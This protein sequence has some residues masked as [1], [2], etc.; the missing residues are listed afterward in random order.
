MPS[1]ENEKKWKQRRHKISK[2]MV[3]R[4]RNAWRGEGGHMT[5]HDAGRKGDQKQKRKEKKKKKR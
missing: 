4:S 2:G 3:S 1:R 5:W